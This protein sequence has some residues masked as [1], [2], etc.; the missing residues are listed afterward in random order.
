MILPGKTGTWNCSFF[1][2]FRCI[3]LLNLLVTNK[4]FLST[5]PLL[6]KDFSDLSR[7]LKMFEKSLDI[8]PFVWSFLNDLGY[9]QNKKPLPPLSLQGFNKV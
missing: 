7:P 6:V 3:N 1:A 5:K 9:P 8:D 4:Y 2:L